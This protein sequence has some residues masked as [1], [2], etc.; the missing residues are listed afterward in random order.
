METILIIHAPTITTIA[1]LIIHIRGTVVYNPITIVVETISLT[2]FIAAIFR[3]FRI[4]A[5]IIVIA[6]IATAF[7]R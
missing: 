5:R 4:H 3:C 7:S 6:I 1:I 2:I